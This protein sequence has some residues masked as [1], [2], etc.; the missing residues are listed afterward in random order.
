MSNKK[1]L[2]IIGCVLCIAV[3]SLTL[4]GCSEENLKDAI[5]TYPEE[6]S[7]IADFKPKTKSRNIRCAC[8]I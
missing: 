8:G 3:S 2:R 7:A 4:F 6:I 1:R 5:V